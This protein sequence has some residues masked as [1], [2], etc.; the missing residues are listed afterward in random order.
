MRYHDQVGF[1]PGIQWWFD[2]CKSTK[3]TQHSNRMKWGRDD[4]VIDIEEASD[5]I[6]HPFVKNTR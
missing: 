5:K 6:Q 3:V 1:S 2:I 4:P